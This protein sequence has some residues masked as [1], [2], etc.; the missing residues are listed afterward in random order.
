MTSPVNRPKRLFAQ[1]WCD[2]SPVPYSYSHHRAQSGFFRAKTIAKIIPIAVE[3][4]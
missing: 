3:I 1:T 4:I 2:R